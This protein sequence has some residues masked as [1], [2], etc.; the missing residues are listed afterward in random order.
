M[1][2]GCEDVVSRNK[3]LGLGVALLVP[4][5][6]AGAPDV[7][8]PL[9]LAGAPDV[10]IETLDTSGFPKKYQ[11]GY[12]VFAVRCSKCH[13][14]SRAINGRL[15]P[16]GWRNYVKKMSRRQGS[17]INETNGVVLVDFLIYY[18]QLLQNPDAGA[19]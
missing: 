7:G 8:T 12:K 17:G 11:D 9:V 10:N 19:P 2:T 1:A 15:S 4:L 16:D 13:T 3:L 5:L 14:L 6:L 18:T